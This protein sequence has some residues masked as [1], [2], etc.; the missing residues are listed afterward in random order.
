VF[1][2]SNCVNVHILDFTFILSRTFR[3][4]K[5]RFQFN[6]RETLVCLSVNEEIRF[7]HGFMGLMCL[8]ILYVS[9]FSQSGINLS[10]ETKFLPS[11]ELQRKFVY[12]NLAA[13]KRRSFTHVILRVKPTKRM[14]S[15]KQLHID[16]AHY[17]LP[18]E[19]CGLC[20]LMPLFSLQNK[21]ETW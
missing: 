1:N 3:N 10:N 9:F 17:L 18:I 21:I 20:T 6:V 12:L 11:R 5:S 16:M 4:V 2:F 19:Q 14:V 8:L 15:V 13:L 7:Q